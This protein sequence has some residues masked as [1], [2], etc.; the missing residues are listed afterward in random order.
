MIAEETIAK[1]RQASDI[2]EVVSHYLP[3]LKRAG[4][5]FKALCPFHQEKTPSFT[6]SPA[7]AIFHC[8]GCG[9]G[10]DVFK[11]VMEMEHCAYPEAIQ[12]LADEKGIPVEKGASG[13]RLSFDHE[14]R[15]V[16]YQLLE[17]AAQFY[18][19]NLLES[20]E[21]EEAWRYLR[22]KRGLTLETIGKF[23]LG[24][25]GT[26]G[27]ALMQTALKSG[28]SESDLVRA[29]LIVRAAGDNAEAARAAGYSVNL[30]RT[31]ATGTG[32]LFAG[33]GGA[34]LSLFY[35][36][37]WAEGL[38]SGQ[39]LMAVTLVIVARWNPVNGFYVS[40]LFGGASALGPALQSIGISGYYYLSGAAPYVL[41]FGLLIASSS[42]NRR[43]V[44]APGELSINR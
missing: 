39:G 16:L 7:K 31:L 35:P 21:A 11:F 25:A 4:K 19:K 20:K 17:R 44:N 40:L 13:E 22:E 14:K 10:G 23:Q 28:C 34:F 24:W 42:R 12:K 9:K 32:G 18:H 33:V 2:A 3:N 43:L 41:T 1:V 8:F 36:G 26:G 30:V 15:K 37:T 27:Q 5:D 38:S 29:G 6:V